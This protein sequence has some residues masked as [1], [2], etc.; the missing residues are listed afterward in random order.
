MKWHKIATTDLKAV[1]AKPR[2]TKQLFAACT[3]CHTINTCT[4]IKSDSRAVVC[5]Y[6]TKCWFDYLMVL[7]VSVIESRPKK[8]PFTGMNIAAHNPVLYDGYV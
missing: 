6:E 2:K 3:I 8:I 1:C 7:I 5:C 4:W